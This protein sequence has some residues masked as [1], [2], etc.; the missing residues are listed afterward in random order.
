MGVR[1]TWKEPSLCL[2]PGCNTSLPI[3]TPVAGAAHSYK[4]VLTQEV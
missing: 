1:G 4:D 3:P 2:A